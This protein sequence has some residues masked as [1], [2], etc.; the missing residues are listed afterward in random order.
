MTGF[1]E[2]KFMAEKFS[3]LVSIKTLNHR[4]FDWYFKGNSFLAE[5]ENRFRQLAQ[6]E[7][8]RGRI[9]AV[10]EIKFFPSF[11]WQVDIDHNLMEKVL[12]TLK[13]TLK[14]FKRNIT[15]PLDPIFRLPGVFTV[16]PLDLGENEILFLENCFMEVVEGVKEQ[17]KKEG[18]VIKKEILS[19]LEKITS[20]IKQI[21]V[22]AQD[23]PKLIEEKLRQRIEK[24]NV[25][26]LAGEERLAQEIF[27]YIQRLDITE[28]IN[29]L[30][31]HL[32]RLL[33]LIHSEEEPVGRKMEF[34]LQEIHR[35]VNTISSK[36]QDLTII[37]FA[38]EI[39]GET[40]KIRQQIQNIE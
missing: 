9:E 36:S 4:Y 1:F 20:W 15:F 24:L 25:G 17:R 27:F 12:N 31:S 13:P 38:V 18:E 6:K 33:E 3:V 23:Q 2:K 7:F 22:L 30:Q 28:E 34:L 8:K 10:L 40:E 21:E 11:N 19:S 5:L 14:K 29:R 16:K 39:K 26:D 37:K 35:E 32:E